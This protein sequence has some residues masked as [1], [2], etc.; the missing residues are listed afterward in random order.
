MTLSEFRD[1]GILDMIKRLEA[2]EDMNTV[3]FV[4]N[5]WLNE[6]LMFRY[7][8]HSLT[9]IFTSSTA[10]FGNS[11]RTATCSLTSSSFE[12]TREAL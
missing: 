5:F 11:I 2:V 3:S 4:L 9:S 1:G 10:G 12:I 6:R 7:M 8:M